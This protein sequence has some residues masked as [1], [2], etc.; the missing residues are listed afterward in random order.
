MARDSW[1]GD[2]ERFLPDWWVLIAMAYWEW[3]LFKR[4]DTVHN[5]WTKF[6]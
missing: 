3:T 2:V 6:R 1:V 4:T 5:L